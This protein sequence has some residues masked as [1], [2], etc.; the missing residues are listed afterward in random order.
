MADKADRIG[1]LHERLIAA[2]EARQ[3][4]QSDV[5]ARAWAAYEHE[6]IERMLKCGPDDDWQR[7]RLQIGIETARHVR[8]VIEHEGATVES[9]QRELDHLEGRKMAAVA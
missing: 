6:L 4:I 3:V 9:L 5:W 7:F 2:S 8:R 1:E